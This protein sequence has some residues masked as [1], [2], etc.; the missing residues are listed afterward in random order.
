[1]LSNHLIFC[2]PLLLLP[3]IFPST[4]VFSNESALHTDESNMEEKK[5]AALGSENHV[6]SWSMSQPLPW[7][8]P[9][10]P[11]IF[12]SCVSWRCWGCGAVGDLDLSEKDPRTWIR[13]GF[14]LRRSFTRPRRCFLP[15]FRFVWFKIFNQRHNEVSHLPCS[16][17]PLD[18]DFTLIMLMDML[19]THAN[20]GSTDTEMGGAQGTLSGA[21]YRATRWAKQ[22]NF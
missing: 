16:P 6:M 3:S 10:H 4:E 12:I 14:L 13:T 2:H 1:M 11:S 7:K 15:P 22:S 20:F 8:F 18:G 19:L 5:M 21:N 9:L 17:G